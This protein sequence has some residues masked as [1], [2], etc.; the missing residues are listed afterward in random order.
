V[1]V[2]LGNREDDVEHI[3]D[4]FQQHDRQLIVEQHAVQHDESRLIQTAKET[5]RE[6]ESLLKHDLDK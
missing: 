3:A 4:L 1:L 2:N 6:L 5:A